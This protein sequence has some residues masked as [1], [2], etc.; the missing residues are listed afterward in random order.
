MSK[1]QQKFNI[2]LPLIAVLTFAIIFSSAA[3]AC[4]NPF[5]W[6]LVPVKLFFDGAGFIASK[7]VDSFSSGPSGKSVSSSGFEGLSDEQIKKI[8]AKEPMTLDIIDPLELKNIIDSKLPSSPGSSSANK[9]SSE[10][11]LLNKKLEIL[12]KLYDDS[13]VDIA[14][15]LTQSGNNASGGM[16]G[17]AAPS[18]AVVNKTI[19]ASPIPAIEIPAAGAKNG[20]KAQG[21]GGGGQPQDLVSKLKDADPNSA[22]FKS[23]F[24]KFK[25]ELKPETKSYLT[26]STSSD[27]SKKILPP[28]FEMKANSGIKLWQDKYE[29]NKL[30]NR[31]WSYGEAPATSGADSIS[32]AYTSNFL[33]TK[34]DPSISQNVLAKAQNSEFSDVKLNQ[35]STKFGWTH[36]AY[37][38]PDGTCHAREIKEAFGLKN[39]DQAVRDFIL[40]T[41]KSGNAEEQVREK[42]GGQSQ[43]RMLYTRTVD[44]QEIKVV[45]D[46]DDKYRGSVITAYP[47]GKVK[48]P[49]PDEI[50]K[51]IEEEKKKVAETAKKNQ[52]WRNPNI[53]IDLYRNEIGKTIGP[54][55]KAGTESKFRLGGATI[56]TGAKGDVLLIGAEAK[57]ASYVGIR[58]GQLAAGLQGSLFAGSRARGEVSTGIQVGQ[59]GGRAFAGGEV[60]AGVGA[61]ADANVG[62]GKEGL[63][64]TL[65]GDAFVGVRAKGQIGGTISHGNTSVTGAVNGTV[66]AGLGAHFEAKGKLSWSG[67]S[68]KVNLGAYLGIG[69]QVGFD[70]NVNFGDALKPVQKVVEKVYD[71][72]KEVV[73]KIGENIKNDIDKTK[74]ALSKLFKWGS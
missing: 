21:S 14:E 31:S 32:K 28:D 54:Q 3:S 43:H 4:A 42:G 49:T 2:K 11:Q 1:Q 34:D 69:G 60:S 74:K 29:D 25:E 7:I 58:N 19:E 70:I 61:N 10:I 59:M 39:Q 41:I 26:Y 30:L 18:N 24:E 38:R 55:I 51:R 37:D 36:I 56:T 40:E 45:V 17:E 13:F 35:G 6:P 47:T 68:A 23:I 62:V 15:T 46:N 71:K 44:G 5:L 53:S 64:A 12:E 72:G 66:G 16:P 50:Q 22:Q 9:I 65:S 20:D 67:V 73:A 57:G 48:A 8:L 52:P 33:N 63:T 27:I